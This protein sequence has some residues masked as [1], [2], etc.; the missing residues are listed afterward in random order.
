MH[1]Q[2]KKVVMPG[3]DPGI[4]V[5]LPAVDKAVDGRVK[6]GYD[7]SRTRRPRRSAL[8]RLLMSLPAAVLS[9]FVS[10]LPA[11]ADLK[12]CNRMS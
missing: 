5:F 8:T 3:L 11:F 7:E 6:P 10:S 9:L 2:K 4:N 1:E 12:L